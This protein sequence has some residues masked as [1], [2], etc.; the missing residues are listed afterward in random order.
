[1]HA[2]I[3][4]DIDQDVRAYA[5]VKH[6]HVYP[7]RAFDKFFEKFGISPQLGSKFDGNASW[8]G[9]E[10]IVSFSPRVEQRLN[11][12]FLRSSG[13]KPNEPR[14]GLHNDLM[15]QGLAKVLF[16]VFHP[17]MSYQMPHS[18]TG[19]LVIL[20]LIDMKIVHDVVPEFLPERSH[21]VTMN[22]LLRVVANKPGTS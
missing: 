19:G 10:H 2:F 11:C 17:V 5:F 1:M 13:Y 18:V 12:P 6:K 15:P 3:H 16:Q 22:A 14:F 4:I 7:H 9:Q 21:L 8:R 20:D